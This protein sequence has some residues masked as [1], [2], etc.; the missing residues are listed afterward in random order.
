MPNGLILELAKPRFKSKLGPA[1]G[2]IDVFPCRVLLLLCH[3]VYDSRQGGDNGTKTEARDDCKSR[4]ET[5]V[6]IIGEKC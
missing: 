2:H 3:G 6:L 5:R 1:A 4:W